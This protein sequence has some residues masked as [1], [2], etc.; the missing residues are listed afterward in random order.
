MPEL[1]FFPQSAEG[2]KFVSRPSN[3][4]FKNGKNSKTSGKN[5]FFR[6]K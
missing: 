1:D 5:S 6:G 3:A 2:E 4:V